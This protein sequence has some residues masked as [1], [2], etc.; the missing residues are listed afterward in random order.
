M[1]SGTCTGNRIGIAASGVYFRGH[2]W[3]DMK[4]FSIALLLFGVTSGWLVAADAKRTT[5]PG[6]DDLSR[7]VATKATQGGH[8][9][10]RDSAGRTVG[11]GE[12]HRHTDDVTR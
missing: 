4:R 9:T 3:L 8:T 1:I 5:A 11:H 2:A 7:Y 6:S 12:H 10:L